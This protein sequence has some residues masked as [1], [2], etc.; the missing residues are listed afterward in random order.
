MILED[1]RRYLQKGI[2]FIQSSDVGGFFGGKP[3]S[4][5]SNQLLACDILKHKSLSLFWLLTIGRLTFLLLEQ[6]IH[7]TAAPYVTPQ[8]YPQPQTIIVWGY[9]FNARLSISTLSSDWSPIVSLLQ[10]PQI[11]F[12]MFFSRWHVHAAFSQHV[13]SF[14]KSFCSKTAWQGS[15]ICTTDLQARSLKM[16]VTQ[17]LQTRQSVWESLVYFAVMFGESW[18]SFQIFFDNCAPLNAHF[19]PAW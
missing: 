19:K 14:T 4:F 5:T 18:R 8:V 17:Y 11:I 9:S 12:F 16:K 15:S 10:K 6:L 2:T 13:S 1:T 7:L 3:D